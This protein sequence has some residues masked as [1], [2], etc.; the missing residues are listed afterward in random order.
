MGSKTWIDEDPDRDGQEIS[1]QNL[2]LE[3]WIFGTDAVGDQR[4]SDKLINEDF[5]NKKFRIKFRSWCL[6]H[7]LH[8]IVQTQMKTESLFKHRYFS[9][10]AMFV[11]VW[12]SSQNQR[13]IRTAW[14]KLYT[15]E[16]AQQATRRLPPRALRGRWC[17][18]TECEAFILKCGRDELIAVF[19]H[20]FV[21]DPKAKAAKAKA[22]KAKAKVRAKAKTSTEQA[23]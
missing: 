12:R 13:K 9:A 6:H 21:D 3:V 2:R 5:K 23:S 10:L 8:L 17:S 15:S 14:A 1:A 7:Q 16:R 18:A 20:I 4:G 22:A 11:N 19:K